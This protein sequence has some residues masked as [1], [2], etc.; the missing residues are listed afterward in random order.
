MPASDVRTP[1]SPPIPKST[2]KQEETKYKQRTNMNSVLHSKFLS[3]QRPFLID[4]SLLTHIHAG[5]AQT[6]M[7]RSAHRFR[8]QIPLEMGTDFQAVSQLPYHTRQFYQP[9]F[10][11][12]PKEEH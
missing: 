8:F 11:I 9:I 7:G 6:Q 12:R 4:G 3:F 2:S 1:E 5:I 10:G